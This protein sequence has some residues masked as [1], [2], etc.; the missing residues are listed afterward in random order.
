MIVVSLHHFWQ[1]ILQFISFRFRYEL[2]TLA[3]YFTIVFIFACKR[4]FGHLPFTIKQ[5]QLNKTTKR[6]M[7]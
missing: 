6:P 4:R 1:D 7:G 3:F 5:K 2:S